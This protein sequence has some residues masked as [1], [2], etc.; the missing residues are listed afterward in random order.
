MSSLAI[1]TIVASVLLGVGVLAVLVWVGHTSYLN[2]IERRLARRKGIYRELVAELAARE[3]ALLEPELHRV[4]TLLDFEA[5]EAVLEEQARGTTDRPS[6]LLEVYDRLGLLD[7][8]IDRLR[9]ARRWRER[10]FAAELLGRVGNAKAV[11]ALL[12]TVQA[13]RTEDGDVREIALRALARIADPRAVDELVASLRTADPWLAPRL[14][15]ILARHGVLVVDPLVTFL[16]EPGR[17]PARAWAANVLGE[18]G[19][20]QAFP[21]LARG[22]ADPDDEVRAKSATALGRLGDRRALA[23][24]L[25]HL[26]ADPAPFVRARIAGALGRFDGPEVIDHLVRGLGDPAWWVRMRSVEALE[27]IGARAE[28]PLL[29]ALEDADPEIRIRAAAGLERLGVPDVLVTLIERGDRLPEVMETLAKFAG[30]GAGELMSELLAHPSGSVRAAAVAAIRRGAP[31]DLAMRLLA[32]VRDDPDAAVRAATLEALGAEGAGSAEASLV[33]GLRGARDS[34]ERVRVITGLGEFPDE[35]TRGTL[36]QII[37]ADPSPEVRSAALAAVRGMLEAEDRI[38]LGRSALDDPSLLVRRAAVG[39]FAGMA[40]ERAF[41]PLLRALRADDD[42]AVLAS[43]AELA[44]AAFP[45]FADLALR[46]SP[47]GPEALLVAQVARYVHH[48]DLPRLLPALA[49]SGSAEV[50]EAVAA[51][52]RHRPGVVDGRALE[53]LTLD[54]V[55]AVRREAAGAAA[56]A[57]AWPLLARMAEDPDAEVRR[58]AALAMAGAPRLPGA[59]LAT[60]AHLADD[61]EMAVRAAAYVGRLLQGTPV[62]LPPGLD[63]AAAAGAVRTAAELPVLRETARTAAGEDRRLAAAL[64]LALLG[65]DVARDVARSDPIPSIRHRV[66]GALELS[67]SAQEGE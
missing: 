56:G 53:E 45:A 12:A 6:W 46:I 1:I 58:E 47:D 44:E 63:P 31:P 48:P 65:D 32:T 40:P 23:P 2:F 29:S 55:V 66:S 20:T 22:L 4:A 5:L 57:G 11:P 21:A 60:L 25:E 7:K 24:L 9:T 28:G 35:H 54:P 34:G 19:A 17:H 59:A 42:P 64:A 39:L 14:A 36:M 8:Y 16:N 52:W 27:Q 41:P 62:P 43:V 26:L 3:H 50:R 15:D 61:Q 67:A 13:T 33:A 38:D 30:A 37:H 51:L 10:A 49:R 18:V